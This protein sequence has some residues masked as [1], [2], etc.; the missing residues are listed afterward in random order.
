MNSEFLRV[1][2]ALA[3]QST[4]SVRSTRGSFLRTC[5]SLERDAVGEAIKTTLIADETVP[6][7][8]PTGFR[9]FLA[10][11]TVLTGAQHNL[12]LAFLIKVLIYTAYSGTINT[13]VWWLP[14]AH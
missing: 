5:F 9:G 12:W 7:V 2:S 1:L 8:V 3:K 13:T 11:F 4:I 6:P 10:K 14:K